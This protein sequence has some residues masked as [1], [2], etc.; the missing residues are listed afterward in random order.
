VFAASA[1][2]RKDGDFV[3]LDSFAPEMRLM[4]HIVVICDWYNR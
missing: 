1:E 3:K 2:I 4:S